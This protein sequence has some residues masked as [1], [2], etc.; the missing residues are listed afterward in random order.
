[1]SK[2]KTPFLSLGSQGTI[3]GVLTTQRRGQA[4]MVREKP[5]PAYRRTLPQVY[6]RW[7]YEDYAYLWTQQ[8]AATRQEYASNGVRHHLT[9]FQYWMKYMLTNLP[10]IVGMWYLDEKTGITVYDSSKNNNPG[11]ILGASPVTGRID[12][13]YHFD[14]LNDRIDFGTPPAFDLPGP[15]S[16]EMWFKPLQINATMGIANKAR[17][18]SSVDCDGWSLYFTNTNRFVW[19]IFKDASA[20][21]ISAVYTD[22]IWY[23]L[24]ASYDLTTVKLNVNTVETSA[25]S[26]LGSL[27]PTPTPLRIGVHQGLIYWGFEDIDHFIL[28]NR[29]PDDTKIARWAERRYPP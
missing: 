10:D 27:L 24:I 28:R 19:R 29:V 25:P 3:G 20:F 15:F 12:G 22:L 5:T 14:G 16:I 9:G 21:T 26:V 6:Q 4:T 11:T 2:T 1:M 13:A 23:H 17:Y 18:S 7:L 8:S